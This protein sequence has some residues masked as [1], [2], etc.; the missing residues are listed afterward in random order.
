M[1]SVSLLLLQKQIPRPDSPL[2]G[3]SHPACG[4][5]VKTTAEKREWEG[6]A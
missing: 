5:L 6:P 2:A 1:F 4:T 3:L